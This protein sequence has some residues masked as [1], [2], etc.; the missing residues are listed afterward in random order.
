[1]LTYQV[2]FSTIT[3]ER[4]EAYLRALRAKAVAP[5][6]RLA[7]VLAAQ[8]GRLADT[9]GLLE[10]LFATKQPQIFAESEVYGDGRD[11]T[12]TELGLLGDVSV[13]APVTV[14]DD[15]RHVDP[16]VHPAPFE[17]TL[18][19]VPGALLRNDRGL[20]P[21]DWPELMSGGAMDDAAYWGLYARRL[22][23]LLRFVERDA[24]ARGVTAVVTIPGVGCGQFAGPFAGTLGTRLQ[25]A[26]ESLLSAMDAELPHVRLV[27]YD[28]YRECAAMERWFGS[29]EFRVRP[30]ALVEEG[31]PQLCPPARYLA[32]A[33]SAAPQR[34]YS[35]VAWDH[36]SW[37]GN[38]YYG[39]ARVTDDGVK[40]AATSAMCALTGI[41]G[42]YSSLRR[43]YEPPIPHQT[44]GDLVQKKGLALRVRGH[45]RVL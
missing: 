38:D 27:Y 28:P 13:A 4:L 12:L 14:Y 29:I 6:A 5:G 40:A 10:A 21:A 30:M 33:P 24:A 31:L 1:M 17:G 35:V 2:V 32:H 25:R 34:L 16:S 18:L 9:S 8:P 43:R 23:P 36:V 7:A 45:E 11:W 42:H 22:G 20:T 3:L 44:W 41:E 19:F 15:G 26:L 37:P 39:G